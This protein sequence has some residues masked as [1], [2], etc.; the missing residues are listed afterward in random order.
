MRS[1]G[2]VQ[3]PGWHVPHGAAIRRGRQS[4][5]GWVLRSARRPWND[6]VRRWGCA[7]W[8]VVVDRWRRVYDA[9]G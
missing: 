9:D 7:N 2:C 4:S 3:F 6:R 5:G 1:L 8:Y